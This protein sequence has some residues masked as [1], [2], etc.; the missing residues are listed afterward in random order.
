MSSRNLRKIE[1]LLRAFEEAEKPIEYFALDLSLPELHRTLSAIPTGAYHHVRCAGLHG[2]YDDGLAWLKRTKTAATA[3]AVLS[4]GSSVGNFSRNDAAKFLHQFSQVLGPQDSLVIGLDSCQNAQQIFQAY[5]DSKGVTEAFYRNGLTHANRLLGYE[6]FKQREW[7]VVGRYKKKL[8]C[9]EAHYAPLLDVNINGI[10]IAKGSE[11]QFETSFKYNSKQRADL[12]Q[13]S[14][15]IHQAALGNKKGD[16]SKSHSLE[17]W[18]FLP[19]S[20]PF[21]MHALGHV[22]DFE[23][24]SNDHVAEL[25]SVP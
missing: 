15:L 10:V 17:R 2:T 1:I 19:Y 16:Y 5:N 7:A 13:A 24:L 9:H 11:I 22:S 21:C 20:V 8:G 14:G 25:S 4:L 23:S 12:W 6:G 3:T 18:T